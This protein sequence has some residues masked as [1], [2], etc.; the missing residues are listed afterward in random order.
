MTCVNQS[1]DKF[2]A[3]ALTE[4]ICYKLAKNQLIASNI[5]AFGAQTVR[6][7]AFT[8]IQEPGFVIFQSIKASNGPQ[9]INYQESHPGFCRALCHACHGTG[10]VTGAQSL[11]SQN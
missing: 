2:E 9:K 10:T 1:F 7:G 8:H 4:E 6:L 3:N 5:L 11:C